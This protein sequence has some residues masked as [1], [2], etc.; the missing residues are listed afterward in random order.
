M[1]F[2]Y[3]ELQGMVDFDVVCYGDPLY[4]VGLTATAIVIDVGTRELFYVEELGSGTH[5]VLRPYYQT[6]YY[7][8]P[9]LSAHE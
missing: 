6:S 5:S 9:F 8:P 3:G 7:L 1:R 4:M 2:P